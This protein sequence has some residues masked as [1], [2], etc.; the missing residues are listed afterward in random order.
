MEP[1]G[2]S[3][4]SVSSVDSYDSPTSRTSSCLSSYY[5]E[6]DW[7][8]EDFSSASGGSNEEDIM[9]YQLRLSTEAHKRAIR[10]M[11]SLKCNH[12]TVLPI[13]ERCIIDGGAVDF[14]KVCQALLG[15]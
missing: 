14:Q 10:K 8:A 9:E 15:C 12:R 3:F 7:E 4:I 1:S 2:P 6:D 5:S 13:G 11:H